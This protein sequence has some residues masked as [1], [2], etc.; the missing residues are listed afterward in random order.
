MVNPKGN[1]NANSLW[2]ALNLLFSSETSI[3]YIAC[4]YNVSNNTFTFYSN[5]SNLS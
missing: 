5:D 1:Y 2:T 3:N 4:I